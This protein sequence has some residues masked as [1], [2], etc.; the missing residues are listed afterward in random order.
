MENESNTE[1]CVYS[2]D[3]NPHFT[4]TEKE[5]LKWMS[6]GRSVKEI[7]DKMNISYDTARTHVENIKAKTGISKNTELMGYYVAELNGKKFNLAKLREYGIAVFLIFVH[8]CK[9]DV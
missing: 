4:K 3:N 7:A 8:I 1:K 5:V 9:I 6:S 2:E